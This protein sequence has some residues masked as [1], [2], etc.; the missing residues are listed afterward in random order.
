MLLSYVRSSPLIAD[1]RR[2]ARDAAFDSGSVPR[3]LCTETRG[4]EK[5]KGRDSDG[6]GKSAGG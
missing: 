6:G 4:D 1:L 3:F 5:Q 2:G